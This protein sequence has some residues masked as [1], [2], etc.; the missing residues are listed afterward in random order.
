MSFKILKYMAPILQPLYR[1]YVSTTRPFRYKNIHILVQPGVFY[2]GFIISTKFF[3]EH[4][5]RIDLGGKT[6]LELGAGSGIIS[7][8]AASKGAMVTASDINPASVQ[9]I[10]KNALLNKAELRVIESDLFEN[11]PGSDFDFI[12]IAPP[13]YPRDPV[14]YAERAWYCGS[15][16]EYYERLFQQLPGF[17]HHQTQVLMILSDDCNIQKIQE[18]GERNG[19][20]FSLVEQKR[21]LGEWN[22]IYRIS[23]PLL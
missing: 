15:N 13:Y 14:D 4:I 11:I 16:F 7:L 23:R 21:K 18:I 8:L 5:G 19:F 12:I 17:Y 22:F 20:G 10:R 9:N 6:L 2:P 1:K 3:L